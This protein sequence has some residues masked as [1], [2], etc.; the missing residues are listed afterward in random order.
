MNSILGNS[1]NELEDF[2]NS[3]IAYEKAIEYIPNNAQV[4]NNYA[5]YLSLREE[6]LEKAEE[7][8]KRTFEMF[9]EACGV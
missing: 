1:Y 2:Q 8:S 9:P 4:L 3:D 6:K 7:M 5:Y